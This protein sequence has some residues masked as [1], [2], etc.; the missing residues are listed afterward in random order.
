MKDMFVFNIAIS[1]KPGKLNLTFEGG[2]SNSRGNDGNIIQCDIIDNFIKNYNHIDI[3]KIDTEGHDMIILRSLLPFVKDARIG[4]IVTEFSTFWYGNT[5]EECINNT[6]TL[7]LEYISLYKYCYALSRRG[8]L[9]LVGPINQD[10]IITF[11]CEH[12]ERH[13]QTDLYFCNTELTTIPKYTY[14]PNKYYA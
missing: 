5:L 6:Y 1:D 11:I 4:A 8:D 12:Y 14:E 7:L 10:N 13:L 9:Y 3:I 2:N